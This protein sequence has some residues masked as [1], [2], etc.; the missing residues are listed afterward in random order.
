MGFLYKLR[1]DKNSKHFKEP[2]ELSNLFFP[3]T[4]KVLCIDAQRMVFC[5][6]YFDQHLA[7]FLIEC[8]RLRT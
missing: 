3:Y 4:L 1:F 2:V 8:G 5:L 7:T 6:L